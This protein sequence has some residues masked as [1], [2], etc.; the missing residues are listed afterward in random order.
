MVMRDKKLLDADFW[1]GVLKIVSVSGFT[2]L[3]TYMMVQVYPLELSDTGF[4]TLGAKL[5]AITGVAFIVHIVVSSMFNLREVRP[6]TRKIRK[7]VLG[8]V[9]V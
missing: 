7:F 8:R 4:F 5:M 9:R 1:S 3:A 6:V 2:I